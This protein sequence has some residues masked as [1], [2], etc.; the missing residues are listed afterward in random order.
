MVEVNHGPGQIGHVLEGESGRG[1]NAAGAGR[2]KRQWQALKTRH[3]QIHTC[4][5]KLCIFLAASWAMAAGSDGEGRYLILAKAQA[6]NR[7][8]VGGR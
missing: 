3:R 8:V 4:A 2:P 6:L 5:P 1:S 7:G